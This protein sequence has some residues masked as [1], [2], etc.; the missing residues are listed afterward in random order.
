MTSIL[1]IALLSAFAH[2]GGLSEISVQMG[3]FGAPDDNWSSTFSDSSGVPGQGLRVAWR[4]G[5]GPD[6]NPRGLEIV[7]DWDHE[8]RGAQLDIGS[9]AGWGDDYADTSV[10]YTKFVGN[11]FALGPRLS[12]RVGDWFVPYATAQLAAWQSR[13]AIDEDIEDDENPNQVAIGSLT[14][15]GVVAV[16]FDVRPITIGERARVGSHLELGYGY[17]LPMR[18][19][20]DNGGKGLDIGSLDFR[21]LTVNWGVGI[22]L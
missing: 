1:G 5:D 12:Y 10:L 19:T 21:G 13:I 8:V 11:R 4:L 2:A 17:A 3:R 14:G 16:G 18:Y 20:A 6:A 22:R 9:D 7:A 15:A